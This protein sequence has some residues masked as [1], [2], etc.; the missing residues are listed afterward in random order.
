VFLFIKY[1]DG[2]LIDGH[3]IDLNWGAFTRS[4]NIIEV[5]SRESDKVEREKK[6]QTGQAS[7]YCNVGL[8]RL[9]L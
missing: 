4:S 6:N 2:F 3:T 9:Y 8:N 1:F 7:M 5:I